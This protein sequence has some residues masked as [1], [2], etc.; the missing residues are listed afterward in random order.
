MAIR[1]SRRS[2]TRFRL[3]R[4][5]PPRSPTPG[6]VAAPRP[7]PSPERYDVLISV[8]GGAA[9]RL[10]VDAA[11]AA[12]TRLAGGKRWCLITGPNLPQADFDAALAKAPEGLEIVPL[13]Q[14]LPGAA[15]RCR[16]VR[17]AGRLQYGLRCP[18]GRLPLDPGSVRRRRRDR[19]DGARERLAAARAGRSRCP[20]TSCRRQASARRSNGSWP[21]RSPARTGSTST[22]RGSPRCGAA[23]A[24]GE[25]SPKPLRSA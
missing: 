14:G 12:A 25:A 15:R 23:R 22:A 1:P 9:G 17:V 11:V 21:R 19:A 16:T 24:V 10:L 7:T 3:P 13:P 6:M 18:A 2:A 4:R 20:R 5:S 8:G